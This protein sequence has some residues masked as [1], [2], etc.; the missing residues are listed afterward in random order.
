V[1]WRWC[2][3]F[4][5]PFGGA[6]VAAMLFFFHPPKQYALMDKSFIYRV[7]ELDLVGNAILLGASIMLP[8]SS[9]YGRASSLGQRQSDRLADRMRIDIYSLLHLAVVESRRRTHAT[10]NSRTEKHSSSLRHVLLRLLC[11]PDPH[12][13]PPQVVPSN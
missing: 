12:V 5:L 6:T 4:N 9:I 10:Q 3:Y 11:D 8:R 7:M 2:F 13:L 1:T